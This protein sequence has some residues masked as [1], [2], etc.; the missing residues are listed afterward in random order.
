MMMGCDHDIIS[1]MS[2]VDISIMEGSF[3]VRRIA[4]TQQGC[5]DY[6]SDT[7]HLS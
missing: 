3:S 6:C 1:M 7:T 4:A 5:G 2:V